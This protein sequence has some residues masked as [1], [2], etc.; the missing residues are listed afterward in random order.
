MYA[1]RVE[2]ACIN[3]HEN[4]KEVTDNSKIISNE[5]DTLLWEALRFS[6][7]ENCLRLIFGQTNHSYSIKVN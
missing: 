6:N 5:I 2:K 7:T 1:F 3:G 4:I